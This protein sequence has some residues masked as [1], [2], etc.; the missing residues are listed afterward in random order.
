MSIWV[1][2]FNI[3]INVKVNSTKRTYRSL[4]N[5]ICNCTW[6]IFSK[7]R[8]NYISKSLIQTIQ[9]RSFHYNKPIF[10]K[11][12]NSVWHQTLVIYPKIM[13]PFL[14]LF[15]SCR[16]FKFLICRYYSFLVLWIW[17]YCKCLSWIVRACKPHPVCSQWYSVGAIRK[18]FVLFFFKV[19][20]CTYLL[21]VV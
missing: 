12:G 8:I 13:F 21:V 7:V 3:F 2:T 19:I 18:C 6:S 10:F 14:I 5:N 15:I 20:N 16:F 11:E 4:P 9:L 1:P 17:N